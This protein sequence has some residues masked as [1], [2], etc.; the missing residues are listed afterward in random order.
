MWRIRS[1]ETGVR[2]EVGWEK[3]PRRLRMFE[4][5]AIQFIELEEVGLRSPEGEERTPAGTA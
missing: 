3:K 4:I 5:A 2:K 1:K